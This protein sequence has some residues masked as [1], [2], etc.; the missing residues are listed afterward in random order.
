MKGKSSIVNA[1]GMG[2]LLAFVLII[3]IGACDTNRV[4]E[5]NREIADGVWNVLDTITFQVDIVDSI[6][7]QNIYINVRNS[8]IYAYSNLFM[9]VTTTFPNGRSSKDTVECILADQHQWLGSG[10]GDIWDHQIL[11]RS[12]VRFPLLGRYTFSYEQAQRSGDKAFIE[13]LPGIIDVG[14][15]IEKQN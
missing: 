4:F 9:F 7:P 8:G 1:P 12:R 5:E 11:Y 13:D 2:W 10:L 3:S 6:N 15:R 14:I